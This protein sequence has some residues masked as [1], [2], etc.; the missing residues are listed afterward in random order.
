M[1][2]YFELDGRETNSKTYSKILVDTI[3]EIDSRLREYE[4]II[5]EGLFVPDYRNEDG[6]GCG[7]WLIKRRG[8]AILA[9]NLKSKSE[10][11]EYIKQLVLEDNSYYFEN[12][13]KSDENKERTVESFVKMAVREVIFCANYVM[14]LLIDMELHNQDFVLGQWV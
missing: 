3:R 12:L 1:G 14:N 9:G 8:I 7:E 10:D 13:F 6:V 2:Y 5:D 11:E 4:N